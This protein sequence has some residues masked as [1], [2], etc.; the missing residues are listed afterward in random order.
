MLPSN[1][2]EAAAKIHNLYMERRTHRAG[3][4]NTMEDIR[5]HYHGEILV[6]LPELDDTERPAVANLIYQGIEQFSLRAASTMPD[7][8]FPPLRPG[9]HSSEERAKKRRLASLGWFDMNRMQHKMRRRSRHLVAY[10]ATVVSLSPSPITASDKRRIPFWQVR[11]PLD[12]FPSFMVD[13]D[14]V[15]PEN[16]IFSSKQTY[17]WLKSTYPDQA[18]T[19]SR[20]HNCDD[21]TIFSLLEY[22]DADETVSIVLGEKPKHS[23][24][25]AFETNPMYLGNASALVL[26]RIPNRANISPVVYAGHIG[27][28]RQT[29]MFDQM[30]GMYQ[31]AA[32]LD[33]LQTIAVF[34]NVFPDEWVESI[35]NSTMSKPRVIEEADGR[36]GVRGIIENGRIN[37]IHLQ[38]GSTSNESIDRLERQARVTGSLPAEL[39]GESGSNIRT[40]RRGEAVMSSAIDMPMAEIQDI[41]ASALEQEIT[42][43]VDIMKSYYGSETK[44]F[45]MGT[46]GKVIN[47]DYTPDTDFET[48][49]CAVAYSMPGADVNGMVVATGQMVG[50]EIL[51]KRTAMEMIPWVEDPLREED[52]IE[53]EG[54]RRA[55]LAG[56]EQQAQQGTLDPL[57]I[58]KVA[59]MKANNNIPIEEALMKVH[60]EE[61]EKQAAAHQEAQQQGQP[62]QPG[63]QGPEGLP[64]AS[65]EQMPGINNMPQ[66]GQ[67]PPPS[68]QAPGEGQQNLSSLLGALGR[69]SGA[70]PAPSPAMSGGM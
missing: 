39:G 11:N 5:K 43:G 63:E 53:L 14:D 57:V 56:M 2:Q 54:L 3:I 70:M 49:I 50:T 27:L 13:P 38:P 20:P 58:A 52:Q 60:E 67:Q 10:G 34:R 40:A 31:R 48:N 47:K 61:Q 16:C 45:F 46:D 21:S 15:H 69:T 66:P 59:R 35:P 65:P 7:I 29:G 36:T 42:I 12:A 64:T 6:P 9:V 33:A 4:Y 68:I 30:R 26:G 37:V 8:K 51:S 18:K 28:D 17:G 44:S 41:L 23:S 22:M 25:S 55:A 24:P 62:Q 32:K 1:N 19:I